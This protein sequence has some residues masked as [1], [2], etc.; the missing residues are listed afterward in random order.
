[1]LN[2]DNSIA[3]RSLQQARVILVDVTKKSILIP[4]AKKIFLQSEDG[5]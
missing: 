2:V 4:L 5:R 1:M 3:K